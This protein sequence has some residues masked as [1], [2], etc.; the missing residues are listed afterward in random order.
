[1]TEEKLLLDL[2]KAQASINLLA[3]T[4]DLSFLTDAK[5]KQKDCQRVDESAQICIQI[6]E[7][8]ILTSGSIIKDT[9]GHFMQKV[10]SL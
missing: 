3:Q 9:L 5:S 10:E 6:N 4:T 7:N 1:M 8:M 2:E